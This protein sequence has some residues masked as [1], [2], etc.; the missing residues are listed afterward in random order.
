[1]LTRCPACQTIFR[2]GPEQL[3]AR[4]GRVRCGHCLNAFNALHN[5]VEDTPETQARECV[6]EESS[7]AP[8]EAP[9]EASSAAAEADP[10]SGWEAAPDADAEREEAPASL[11]A[12]FRSRTQALE[13]DRLH[14][15]WE[16]VAPAG[17]PSEEAIAEPEHGATATEGEP[18]PAGALKDETPVKADADPLI[19][20]AMLTRSDPADDRQENYVRAAAIP[21]PPPSLASR[22]AP[23]RRHTLGIAVGALAMTLLVQGLFLLRQPL[24]QAIPAL[25]EPLVALCRHVG[26]EIPLPREAAEIS[27][28]ASD[29]HPEPGGQGD[30]VLHVTLRNRAAY[31][32]AYPHVELSL[33][34]GLDKA[35][36]RRVF[37]PAEWAP[38]SAADGAFAAGTTA[39]VALP[40]N[41]AGVAA[42]GYR[43][44]A[45]YP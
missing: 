45:F 24:S 15:E 35:L 26:C 44:Y 17:D 20:A 43:V 7:Q 4:Q 16:A 31:P 27:I 19:A 11:P 22:E 13:P 21:V 32:Q 1:M 10:G 3:A 36:A 40:F 14:D 33:T 42:V 41:A 2:V 39:V 5:A 38:G 29:L 12:V 30:F 25:R 8:L 34:D 6:V 9:W 28:E 18:S 37:S 23:D